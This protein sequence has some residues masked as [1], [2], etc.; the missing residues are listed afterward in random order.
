MAAPLIE[1]KGYQEKVLD[2]LESYLADAAS[3]DP[4]IAFYRATH[5]PYMPVPALPDLPYICMQSS[6]PAGAR[7]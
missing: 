5:R 6:R 3:D 4:D 1:L 7:R 2:A